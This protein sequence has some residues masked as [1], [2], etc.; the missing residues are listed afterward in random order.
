MKKLLLSISFILFALLQAIATHNRAGEITYEHIQNLTYKFTLVTYTYKPS[1]ADRPELELFWGDG[2][3]DTIPRNYYTDLSSVMRKNVYIGYHTYLGTGTFRISLEDPNRNGGVVNIPGSVNIAF[4]IETFLTINA[5][6]VPNSSP[7]L[8][9]PPIDNACLHKPYIHNPGAYDKDGDSLSYRLIPCKGANGTSIGTYSYP[10]TSNSFLIN[11]TTGDLLWDS[12]V[13]SGEYNVAILIE[14]W[15]NGQKIGSVLRDMQINVVQCNNDPPVIAEIL[16]TCIEAG[17][18][19]QFQVSATD[20][21]NDYI[22]LTGTGGPLMQTSNPATF[23]QPVIGK[24]YVSSVFSWQTTCAHVQKYPY[25]LTFKATDDGHGTPVNLVDIETVNILVVGPSPKNLTATPLGNSI[26]LKWN[27]SVCT[28]AL[29][30]EIYRRNGFFGFFPDHCETGVPA[31]TGYSLI[32]KGQDINDTV[33]ID[34]ENGKGLI[35]GVDYCYMVVAH[36]PDGAKSYASLE[37]CATLIKDVPIITNVSINTTDNTT[38][39]A[40][41]AWSKPTEFDSLQLPG[42]YK[43]L[44]YRSEGMAN[45]NYV[46]I[47]SLSSINDTTYVD[48]FLNTLNYP[49]FYRIDF[50]SN[51]TNMRVFVGSTHIASSVFLSLIPSDN[52]LTLS[53]YHDVPWT[54]SEY[55][56]YKLNPVT[57]LFDSIG[58][59]TNTEFVDSNLINGEDYCY[60]V[61]STGKYTASGIINPIINY[62][63]ISCAKPIDMEAPCAPK[64]SVRTD[65]LNIEN[66]LT[67]NN[68]NNSCADDVVKY[69]VYY[70]SQTNGDF[71]IIT[72]ISNPNDTVYI[73]SGLKSIAGCYSVVAVD[74]FD[75]KSVFSNVVCV[76]IDSCDLYSLPNVFT[77]N[78]DGYNDFFIPFPYNFV[79]HIDLQIFNRWGNI[80]FVSNDPDINWDGKNKDS[81][82]IVPDGV[83]FYVCDVF[84]IRLEGLVKRT[85]KG[86]VHVYGH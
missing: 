75:N 25:T 21:N 19:I 82:N 79:D 40:Y 12:P 13:V 56:I 37:A 22:T 17:T 71:T 74:S 14:E 6:M 10:A 73:H 7:V 11:A 67:W 38:G 85:I 78:G 1:P 47:D 83:Y 84:E 5:F 46:L 8:L 77:P 69:E 4:Y 20:I 76:D 32:Y 41:I 42:P 58:W 53:W 60:K 65:C 2:T 68:P 29:G 48:T 61:K 70:S 24:A 45:P 34:N 86:F 30:Y 57:T 62:S 9:V 66:T 81:H 63:Q 55:T 18:S 15:R 72:I 50:Y 49:Y 31:Y 54:N 16:D 59:T 33:Y 28:N 44:I 51:P 23:V 3:S 27:K 64:L 35:H 43:Y 36:Y 39:S 80:V 26:N 52:K